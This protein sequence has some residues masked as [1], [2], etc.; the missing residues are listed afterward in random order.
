MFGNVKGDASPL[1]IRTK[2]LRIVDCYTVPCEDVRAG[3]PAP[4]MIASRDPSTGMEEVFAWHLV[5][6]RQGIPP[7]EILPRQDDLERAVLEDFHRHVKNSPRAWWVH[8]G[9][10]SI[11][12]GF[13]ALI[14][15]NRLRCNSLRQEQIKAAAF[16]AEHSGSRVCRP[17]PRVRRNAGGCPDCCRLPRPG[18]N[19]C[20]SA[21]KTS[22]G[23]ARLR[24]PCRSARLGCRTSVQPAAAQATGTDDAVCSGF[25]RPAAPS[26]R[27]VA[28]PD[29]EQGEAGNRQ[30]QPQLLEKA[31][32]G[33]SCHR[34]AS[35][36]REEA[37]PG[38]EPGMA[39]LQSAALP[40]G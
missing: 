22:S 18:A 12:F 17:D 26:V 32:V 15:R 35:S 13:P 2:R 10:H 30:E 25:A 34:Q 7:E 28:P 39:D 3:T 4:V 40:L 19:E 8:W 24:R 37:P 21:G 11:E 38:F 27:L 9:L 29:T 33:T 36:V 1:G 20:T 14:Q 16:V 6:E 23:T 5:A 31:E